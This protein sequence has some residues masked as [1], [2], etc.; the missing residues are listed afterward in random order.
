MAEIAGEAAPAVGLARELSA[1]AP[2]LAITVLV[3][4]LA[5]IAWARFDDWR[6]LG[7]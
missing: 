3:I 1:I 5:L 6:R 7:R 4:A 2:W